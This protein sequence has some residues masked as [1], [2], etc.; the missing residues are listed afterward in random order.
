[1]KALR[2]LRRK[3]LEELAEQ[4][5]PPAGMSRERWERLR[6]LPDGEFYDQLRGVDLPPRFRFGC[7]PEGERHFERDG[8]RGRRRPERRPEHQPRDL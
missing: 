7:R 4:H 2:Q 1:M 8:S 3:H 6:S 5:G